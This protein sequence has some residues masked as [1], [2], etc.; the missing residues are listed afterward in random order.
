MKRG[1]WI[2]LAV[3]AVSLAAGIGY[4]VL[5]RSPEW[6][7]SSPAALAEFEAA[8]DARMKYYHS[9]AIA[10][11]ERAIE[12]DP[13]F[14]IA[15]LMLANYL[16]SD[17]KEGS[18]ALFA[19]VFAADLSALTPREQMMVERTR[20]IAE[21]ESERAREITSAYIERYPD[22]PYGLDLAATVAWSEG[23]LATA[24]RLFRHI[25]DIRPNWVGAYNMLGYVTMRQG[26]FVEA[27]EYL[28]SYRFIA[29][30]QANPHDSLGELFTLLGRYEMAEESVN[31]ALA[32][33]PDFYNSY[34]TLFLIANLREDQAGMNE[35]I[36]RAEQAEVWS[37]EMLQM[38]RCSTE[39]TELAEARDWQSIVER[40]DT[41]C[42]AEL[43]PA[44][45]AVVITHR[46]AC[47]V[48]RWELADRLEERVRAA[49]EE[50]GAK[51]G[52]LDR[53]VLEAT[54]AHMESVRAAVEGRLGDAVARCRAADDGLSYSGA[55]LGVFKLVNR[56]V[57]VELL[58]AKGDEIEAHRV[59]SQVRA[60][61]PALVGTFEE[62]GLSLLGLA[63]R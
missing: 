13:G 3:V 4:S 52:K 29:P 18:K 11:L 25:L 33:K 56:L 9:E 32:I 57:L 55:A 50:K 20:A 47:L 23:D 16:R 7:T 42:V 2:L 24:E 14:V 12:L 10:H 45:G 46:A 44:D 26:R 53:E 43:G 40:A 8:T 15:K 63:Q 60:V 27:E 41:P 59:L 36:R 61:N 54:L 39:L 58:R 21:G 35:V 51:V 34:Y 17:H 19:E 6:T 28:T 38:F 37:P 48:G 1:L 30:D 49:V 62:R 5:A 31:R 22:D